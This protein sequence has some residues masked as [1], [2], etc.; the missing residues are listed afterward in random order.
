MQHMPANLQ[1]YQGGNTYIPAKAAKQMAAYMEKTMPAHMKEYITPYMHQQT[2]A[3]LSSMDPVRTHAPQERA[4][5]PNLMRRDHSAYGEQFSVDLENPKSNGSLSFSPQYAGSSSAA[6]TGTAA[7]SPAPVENPPGN[8]GNPYDFI[9]KED[10]KP[11]RSWLP[12]GNSKSQRTLIVVVIAAVIMLV[13]VL[14]FAIL[15]ASGSAGT[16]QMIKA[17]QQQEELARISELAGQK[18]RQTETKNIAALTA[19]TMRADQV[20]LKDYLSKS[21]KKLSGK[22]LAMGKNSQTDAT[23]TQ[24]EQTNNFDSTFTSTLA[25]SVGEY[26]KTLKDAH[27]NTSSANGKK[28]LEQLYTHALALTE[29]LQELNTGQ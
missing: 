28:L 12:S 20:T 29:K 7:A 13:G 10:T 4:P 8:N 14:L 27:D 1:K 25:K 2:T 19:Q 6:G 23:L 9:L 26:Q 11:K 3:G 21:G 17:A 16:T 22:D 5:A 24:A 18:A 15:S